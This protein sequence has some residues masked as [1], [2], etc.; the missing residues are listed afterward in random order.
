MLLF[1]TQTAGFLVG[2][3]WLWIPIVLLPITVSALIFWRQE[4][5]RRNSMKSV[6]LEIRIPRE[7]KKSARAMEQI[8]ASM[9]T[10]RTAAGSFKDH[11]IDGKVAHW[12]SLE[13]ASFGGEIHFYVRVPEKLR[14]FVEAPFFSY[15][16]DI[17]LVLVDDYAARFPEDTAS[18][19]EAG[20]D[21]W[22]TELTLT[23]DPAYP[24]KTYE[25]FETLDEE[26]QFDPI[27][28]ILEVL[29]K[30]KPGEVFALQINIEPAGGRWAPNGKQVIKELR[31]DAKPPAPFKLSGALTEVIKEVGM[32]VPDAPAKPA[33][34]SAEKSGPR[35]PGETDLIKAVEANISK[36]G[37]NT[38]IRMIYLAPKGIFS[39]A[40]V[41]SGVMAAFNQYSAAHMNGF[42]TNKA[43]AVGVAPWWKWPYFFGAERLEHRKSR[44]LYNFKN[45]EMPHESWAGKLLTSTVFHSNFDAKTFAM[46]TECLATIFH[47]PTTA[48]L[49]APHVKRSE[50]RKV[51]PSAGLS[52]YGDEEG[53]EKFL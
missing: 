39:S 41:A 45:R 6:L 29:G 43:M 2:L 51:G 34:A 32:L 1:I 35:T 10:M 22:G 49:T 20:Q 44:M 37:F 16:S 48:V 24:I 19:Y 25:S 33:S 23:K 17:E 8:L 26:T 18:M 5:F 14:N 42:G 47:P 12:F 38:L 21:V 9:A 27:S 7:V 28:N 3:W 46:N 15:Y 11:Y 50:S 53:I 4:S 36:P 31:G 30:L 52:I 40:L 13:I